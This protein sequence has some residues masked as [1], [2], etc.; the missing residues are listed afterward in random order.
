MSKNITE[1][2]ETR[3]KM[4]FTRET[5]AKMRKFCRVQDFCNVVLE[6]DKSYTVDEAE[7][8]IEAARGKTPRK[9]GDR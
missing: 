9:E 5:I 3:S 2:D 1:Q 6:K 4:R 8:I 7:K